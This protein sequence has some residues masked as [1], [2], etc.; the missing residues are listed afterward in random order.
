VVLAIQSLAPFG[1]GNPRPC[2]ATQAVELVEPPRCVGSN[3]GHLQFTVRQ[4]GTYRKAIA[5]GCG[6]HAE[7]L[8]EQRGVQ[9]AFEPI[10]SEWQGQRRVELKVADWRPA[11]S[12]A[13]P[14]RG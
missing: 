8:G 3:G 7:E 5:F 14:M 10:I 11:Q 6:A 4:N 9:L 13:M 1:T 12:D 2:L